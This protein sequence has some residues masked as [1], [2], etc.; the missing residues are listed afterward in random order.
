[1]RQAISVVP[2]LA[3]L[4]A[5]GLAV[6][7]QAE[8]IDV[9][10]RLTSAANVNPAAK[11]A[12]LSKIGIKDPQN[13]KVAE[14]RVNQ[15][16]PAKM[17]LKMPEYK[18]QYLTSTEII[19]CGETGTSRMVT[20]A[21]EVT[22]STS[23]TASDTIETGGE[24]SVSAEYM[25]VSGSASAHR[26]YSVTNSK[27]QANSVTQRIED[28]TNITFEKEGG[29]ISVLEAKQLMAD[30]IPWT[31]T[32]VPEDGQSVTIVAEAAPG[33]PGSVCLFEHGLNQGK[34]QCHD[35]PKAVARLEGGWND[36]LSAVEIKGAAQITLFEHNDYGGRS[37]TLYK[38][39]GMPQGWND[40]TSSF[41]VEPATKSATATFGDIKASIPEQHRTFNVSGFISVSDAKVDGKRIVN[42]VVDE[43]E[44]KETCSHP[45]KAAM[46]LAGPARA[47]AKAGKPVLV[48]ELSREE[49][50]K[51]LAKAKR[52]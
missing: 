2:L 18:Y 25:G 43:A 12:V 23:V 37:I 6:P 14:I 42:Y 7:V 24:V 9:K 26:N 40:I 28:S 31:A 41:K 50:L 36:I 29:R 17:T 1:M 45:P 19:N 5:A 4:A 35:V 16:K 38:T 44:V 39:G 47:G 11:A 34:K 48:R 49:G 13:W 30:K 22:N 15:V 3:A 27:E 21:K 33:T 46:V 20:L 32:F 10:A 51:K 8:K 52:G